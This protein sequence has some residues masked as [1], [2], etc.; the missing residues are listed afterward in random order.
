[1]YHVYIL[2][3]NS[4]QYYFYNEK[5]MQKNI[6]INVSINHR[7]KMNNSIFFNNDFRVVRVCSVSGSLYESTVIG[8]NFVSIHNNFFIDDDHNLYIYDCECSENTQKILGIKADKILNHNFIIDTDGKYYK[9][10]YSNQKYQP[11]I[12]NTNIANIKEIYD[13][14]TIHGTDYYFVTYNGDIYFGENIIATRVNTFY[15]YRNALLYIDTLCDNLIRLDLGCDRYQFIYE[16]TSLGSNCVLLFP[17]IFDYTNNK[18]YSFD[19]IT[20][21]E[22]M[23]VIIKNNNENTPIPYF[24]SLVANKSL[25]LH[26]S[27]FFYGLTDSGNIYSFFCNDSVFMEL[28]SSRIYESI[29]NI[30][31]II[32]V[33][34]DPYG[35]ELHGHDECF[36]ED[37]IA[38][39][40]DQENNLLEIE[41]EKII[42][43]N[44]R[45]CVPITVLKNARSK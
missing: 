34:I 21:N 28:H 15:F 19:R 4:N 13:Y 41:G 7:L 32:I 6:Y 36:C 11:I 3:L 44:M 26:E 31:R 5:L 25:S 9:I 42:M 20:A 29:H 37:Y 10:E 14:E 43:T 33:E 16:N 45:Y 27:T 18:I 24:K 22:L 1:M 12:V 35:D 8:D 39:G 30:A 38:V 40:I 17:F 2:Q 23:T